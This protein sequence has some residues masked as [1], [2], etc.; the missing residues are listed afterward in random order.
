[1]L[2]LFSSLLFALVLLTG[3]GG[4]SQPKPTTGEPSWILNPNKDGKRGAVGV[5]GPTYDQKVSSQRKLAITR[6]LDELS[7]QQGVKVALNVAKQ[8]RYQNGKGNTSMD[9]DASYQ[10][11]ATVT[12]HI[13]DVWKNK[14][15]NEIYVWMVMD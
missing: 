15:T 9:V 2:K 11:S 6:A 1:M 8:E 4:N 3:C 10:A 12:A 5:A 7:L 14:M 13:E